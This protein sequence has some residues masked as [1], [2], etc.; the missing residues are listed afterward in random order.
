[1]NTNTTPAGGIPSLI[2]TAPEQVCGRSGRPN[3][4]IDRHELFTA[5]SNPSAL[6]ALLI[7]GTLYCVTRDPRHYPHLAPLNEHRAITDAEGTWHVA[8]GVTELMQDGDKVAFNHAGDVWT[9]VALPGT[10]PTFA[11][12]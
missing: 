3:T 6:R 7:N 1:M 9:L 10:T 5:T 8:V 2:T 4:F 12:C 11:V